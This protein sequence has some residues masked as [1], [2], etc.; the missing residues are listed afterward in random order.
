ML[1]SFG[2]EQEMTSVFLKSPQ[3]DDVIRY[4]D[5]NKWEE[6][7][8]SGL[9]GIP[10][11]VFAFGKVTQSGQRIIRTHAFELKI[12]NWRRALTQAFRYAAFAHYSTVVLDD[13]HVQPAL[14]SLQSFKNSNI[15]LLS[16]DRLGNIDSHYYPKFR[17]PYSIQLYQDYYSNLKLKLF[18]NPVLH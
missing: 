16:I 1:S 14:D 6:F 18:N 13:A 15:G 12:R 9:F 8:A 17:R 3:F 4:S 2:T 5:W 11:I 7:E 10:D